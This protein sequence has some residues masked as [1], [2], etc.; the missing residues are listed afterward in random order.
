MSSVTF[1]NLTS[2]NTLVKPN[3]QSGKMLPPLTP[4]NSTNYPGD[5]SNVDK[6]IVNNG[7]KTFSINLSTV[8]DNIGNKL[9]IYL[10]QGDSSNPALV[11]S[12]TLWIKIDDLSYQFFYGTSNTS[13]DGL[14]KTVSKPTG[15]D[16]SM[17]LTINWW[18]LLIIMVLLI[19]IT[20]VISVFITKRVYYKN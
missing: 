7:G 6:L 9:T 1:I 12:S 5:F 20:A 8:K 15:L 3:K 14:V 17:P 10:Y 2:S 4:Q 16:L 13:P 18:V 11:G 19:I